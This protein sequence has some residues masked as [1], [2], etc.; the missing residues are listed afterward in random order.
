MKA[1]SGV[2]FSSAEY[3]LAVGSPPKGYHS[4]QL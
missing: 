2:S 4:Q 1:E 3:K